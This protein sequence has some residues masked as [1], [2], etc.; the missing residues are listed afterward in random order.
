MRNAEPETAAVRDQVSAEEWKAR[1]ELAAV[2]RLVA[3]EGWADLAM[4]HAS[5]RVPGTTDQYLF[6][7]TELTFDEITASSLHKVGGDGRLLMSSPYPPHKFAYALQMPTYRRFSQANCI[8]HL[9]THAGTAV[10]M[11]EEGL[12]P[13]S[14]YALWLGP[15]SYLDYGGHIASWE[16]GERLARAFGNGKLLMMR[17]HG[18]MNWGESIGQAYILAWLLTRACEKQIMAQSGQSELYR[19][20]PD[21]IAHTP[22]QARSITAADGAF[23]LQ[24]WNAAV[25]RVNRLSP[26]YKT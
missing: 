4:A 1:E 6:L 12:L 5:A 11:Q 13:S 20:T 2:F 9:H 7:P 21:V 14:Q 10:S 24:N 23:G 17:C 16:E 26:D 19:P 8:I 22:E 3:L 25:R 18:T 15:I